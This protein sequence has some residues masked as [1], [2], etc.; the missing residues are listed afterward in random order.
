MAP[1]EIVSLMTVF[2]LAIAT[3]ISNTPLVTFI[4][5][6]FNH[7]LPEELFQFKYVHVVR[8]ILVFIDWFEY[9]ISLTEPSL[10]DPVRFTLD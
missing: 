1:A 2:T 10:S 7:L 5:K 6:N 8:P 9:F 3:L 4:R